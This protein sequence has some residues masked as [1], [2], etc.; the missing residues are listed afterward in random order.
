[1]ITFRD[2]L[3]ANW[4]EHYRIYQPN[5]DCLIFESFRQ[6][7]SLYF[8]KEEDNKDNALINVKYYSDNGYCD[9][10]YQY[11]EIIDKETETLLEVFGGYEVFSIEIGSFFP[12]IMYTDEN[13]QLQ[14]EKIKD[15]HRPHLES[16]PCYDLFIRCPDLAIEIIPD[17]LEEP[18]PFD[19][20][21]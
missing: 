5:R 8:F 6:V 9:N 4:H 18:F 14:V 1:M 10:V 16:L 2:F 3:K 17:M 12:Q 21:E 13:N 15:N 19:S 11:P 7:H 20:E